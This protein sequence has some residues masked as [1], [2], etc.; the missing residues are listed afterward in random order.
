[1]A[2]SNKSLDAFNDLTEFNNSKGSLAPLN[3]MVSDLYI[4]LNDVEQ[5]ADAFTAFQ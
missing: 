4:L 3:R 5:K 1:M 2:V